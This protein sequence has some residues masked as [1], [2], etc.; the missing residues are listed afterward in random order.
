VAT[1]ADL[2]WH[3]PL[4]ISKFPLPR[5]EH[6]L[7]ETKGWTFRDGK[8]F[9]QGSNVGF[10][11][12]LLGHMCDAFYFGGKP[13][14]FCPIDEIRVSYI[15]FD[16][17]FERLDQIRC[18]YS[19]IQSK[20]LSLLYDSTE[21]FVKDLNQ[22]APHT[23]LGQLSD[24]K[25][26]VTICNFLSFILR[27]SAAIMRQNVFSPDVNEIDEWTMS[28][29][30]ALAGQMGLPLDKRAS[31]ALT[32]QILQAR[33]GQPLDVVF[34]RNS[35]AEL[36]FS[37]SRGDV[38][39]L[40]FASCRTELPAESL[41]AFAKA[42][43]RVFVARQL[44]KAGYEKATEA[45]LDILTDVVVFEIRSIAAAAATIQKGSDATGKVVMVQALRTCG[46][47]TYALNGLS[48]SG[49]R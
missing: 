6:L 18:D 5:L 9:C 2:D 41:T 16:R 38:M 43:I 34:Q 30:T 37:N 13:W 45:V 31:Y 21:S 14:L 29:A 28:R 42:M 35:V 17:V 10:D 49:R 44:A 27:S 7:K 23:A 47:E 26:P 11:V 8:W 12:R 32:P 25:I 40:P 20:L 36:L 39:P 24:F 46:F 22:F 1:D 3:N 15:E 19:E 48:L 33:A 4:A